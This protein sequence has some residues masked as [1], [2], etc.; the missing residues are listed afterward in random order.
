M[1]NTNLDKNKLSDIYLP[2][3]STGFWTQESNTVPLRQINEASFIY[4]LNTKPGHNLGAK[5][6]T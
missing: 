1:A 3:F 6:T 4:S 5:D 2:I